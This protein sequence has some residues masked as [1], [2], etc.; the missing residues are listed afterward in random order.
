M[1]NRTVCGAAIA[2]TVFTGMASAQ[3]SREGAP[4]DWQQMSQRSRAD[5]SLRVDLA[6]SDTSSVQTNGLAVTMVGCLERETDYRTRMNAGKGGTLGTGAGL[7]NEFVLVTGERCSSGTGEAFEL[8]GN[9]EKELEPFVGFTVEI[10]GQLKPAKMDPATGR[11]T[12][13]FDPLGQD[14]RL[15]E[16]EVGGFREPATASRPAASA[17]APRDD[18]AN[19][20]AANQATTNEIPANQAV[21]S[22]DRPLQEDRGVATTGQVARND[23]DGDQLPRTASPLAATGLL[24]LLAVGSAAALRAAQKLPGKRLIRR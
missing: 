12:G 23:A 21:V 22:N 3:T 17:D 5:A 13:G 7:G 16:V 24:G 8:T 1:V 6:Q 4:R 14:L 11:P 2:V 9:R 19:Q 18:A 20:S 15:R 10:T